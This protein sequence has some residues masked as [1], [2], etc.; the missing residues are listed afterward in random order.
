MS[1]RFPGK[2][3][4]SLV[5]HRS[6]A[7]QTGFTLVELLVV[8]AIIGVLVALLLPAVQAAR[9]AARR[10]HCRNNLRQLSLATL[11]YHE[12]QRVFPT[13]EVHGGPT[14]EHGPY[15]SYGQ[16]NAPHCDWDG[17]IG[18]WMNLIFP[19][20]ERQAEYDR[21][22]FNIHPQYTSAANREIMQGL[23]D[24]FLCP[25]DPYRGLTT[26][27]GP[28]L[29]RCRIAHYYAVNGEFEGSDLPHPDGTL[30]LSGGQP[31]GHCNAHTGIF[32][33]DSGIRIAQITDGTSKTAMFCEVWGRSGDLHNAPNESSRGMNLHM[34]VYFDWP[35]NAWV[36]ASNVRVKPNPWKPNSFHPGGVHVSYADGSVHFIPD[37]IQLSTF[38]GLA[39]R[40]GEEVPPEQFE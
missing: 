4:L 3:T 29:N 20:L 26:A 18:I 31:Y 8:I 10:T 23:Y 11:N 34:A 7:N 40:E 16:N 38:R 1:R 21:L 32:Y 14:T 28:D 17:R 9:E 2:I 15:T 27:W 19:Q 12:A 33:N 36:V 37:S 13:G 39:T 22:D 35:P 6:A 30:V 24:E 25:S 5:R